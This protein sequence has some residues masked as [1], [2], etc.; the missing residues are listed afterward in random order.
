[1]IPLHDAN[2]TR[3]VPW[4]TLA[5]I[6]ANVVVFLF[7]QPTFS[8]SQARQQFFFFCQAEIPW[9]VSHQT[10]L[11]QGG[12]AARQE[13][14]QQFGDDAG[15]FLQSRLQE[16]C[17]QKSWLASVF[18]AM[19]LHEGWLHIGGN[20]LFLY[21]FGNNIEDRMGRLVYPIFY[22]LG[23]LAAAGLQL[24][25]GP[26][27]VI[28]NLGASG[29]IA[30]VLGAYLVLYP[31]AR[32]TT[33]VFFFFITLIE[34]PAAAVLGIWFVIQFFSGVGGLGT[35]VNGG[36]AYW[37]HVGGFAFGAL[38]AWALYRRGSASSS[39]IERSFPT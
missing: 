22:L 6:A 12:A 30:A 29:A 13:I 1:V 14:D 24:A 20:M 19:F 26:N 38:V 27:A 3:R 10:N 16:R 2:P 37:A 36:V 23:G 18:V 4:I 21:I 31:R 25:F 39:T 8:S 32:V 15:P 33:L 11:A 7:W 9:E 17:P 35:Q 5:I 28:P 34:L